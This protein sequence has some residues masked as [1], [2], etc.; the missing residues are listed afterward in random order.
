MDFSLKSPTP[1]LLGG[2][3]T[4]A[5]VGIIYQIRRGAEGA[6]CVPEIKPGSRVLLFGDSLAVGLQTPMRDLASKTGCDFTALAVSGTTMARWINDAQLASTL[7]TFQPTLTITSLGTNDSKA[8]YTA[9]QLAANVQAIHNRA[10]S[11]GAHH[12]W[13][14]PPKLPF[15]DRVSSIIH[16]QNIPAF[17]SASLPLP[18]PDQ[19]HTTGRGYAGWAE[20]IWAYLMCS[21]APTTALSSLGAAPRNPQLPS[22]FVPARPPQVARRSSPPMLGPAR[23]RRRAPVR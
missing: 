20:H 23:G 21:P 14:L 5:G 3:I 13:V 12:L 16:D 15:P 17:P 8:N 2:I 6:F 19:I 11:T 4:L 1:W 22:M 9:E 7:Q 18:Q 10:T